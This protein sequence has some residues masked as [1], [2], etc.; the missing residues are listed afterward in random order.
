MAEPYAVWREEGLAT[1]VHGVAVRFLELH[2]SNN[3]RA[4]VLVGAVASRGPPPVWRVEER[5]GRVW[6]FG[7][8]GSGG[9]DSVAVR[10]PGG[11]EI[12][13]ETVAGWPVRKA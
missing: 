4:L 9:S 8:G 2:F 5:E 6:L 12:A 13:H 3:A 1:V 10:G 7:P 11:I